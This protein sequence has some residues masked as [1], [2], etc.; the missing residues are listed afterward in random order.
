MAIVWQSV[1]SLKNAHFVIIYSSM[2]LQSHMC[3]FLFLF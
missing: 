1:G 2:Y 3:L